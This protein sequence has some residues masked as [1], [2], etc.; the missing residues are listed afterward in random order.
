MQTENL[1]ASLIRQIA[2]NMYKQRSRIANPIDIRA[3]HH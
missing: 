3:R 1:P 2:V